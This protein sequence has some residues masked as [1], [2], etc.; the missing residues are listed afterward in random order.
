M[1]REVARWHR[2]RRLRDSSVGKS[3]RSPDQCRTDRVLG[4]GH[5]HWRSCDGL[6]S[7]F[8]LRILEANPPE[9]AAACLRPCHR[10]GPYLRGRHKPHFRF[11]RRLFP[12]VSHLPNNQ[13]RGGAPKLGGRTTIVTP[14]QTPDFSEQAGRSLDPRGP[15]PAAIPTRCLV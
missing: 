6:S 1:N 7:E 12:N 8:C 3:S 11:I 15:T 2:D 9:S 5:G 10:A 4:T 14:C 13:R